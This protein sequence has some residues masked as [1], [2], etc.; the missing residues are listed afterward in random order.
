MIVYRASAD[1]SR[2]P[3]TRS[4]VCLYDMLLSSLPAIPS[5]PCSQ[6]QQIYMYNAERHALP[7]LLLEEL[8]YNSAREG[9]EQ[10]AVLFH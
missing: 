6:A 10:G 1:C 3:Y 5:T 2:D 4:H 9:Q 8:Y 7:S